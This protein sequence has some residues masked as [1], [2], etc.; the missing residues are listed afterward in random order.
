M[1]INLLTLGLAAGLLLA[2][3]SA[4]SSETD[5]RLV[6][7]P[8]EVR[9]AP[10]GFRCVA[11]L[12]LEAPGASR[13][14]IRALLDEEIALA[15]LPPIGS[16]ASESPGL[17]IRLGT[18]SGE[19]AWPP[20]PAEGGPEAY[21]LSIR[22]N[23]VVAVG[24]EVN[25]LFYA[26]QTLR[27]LIRANRNG[28][29]LPC[30]EIRDWPSLRWRAFQDDMTR[31]P[32]SR[33]DTLRFEAALGA[34]LKFNL[35]TYY[36]EYQFAFRK[37]PEIG[38][39]DGSLTP[40]D[41][42]GLVAFA[43]PF[44][45][46]VLGNQQSFG[47]FGRILKHPTYAAL[48]EN[49]DVLTPVR[50]ETYQLLDDFY[51]EVCPLV[52][53][54]WFNVCCD[55]TWGLGSGPSKDLAA[56]IGTGGVYVQHVRRVHDLLRD[57]HNKRMMMWGDIILQHPDKLGEIPKDMIM[58]TWGYDARPSFED[59]IIPFARSGFEFFVCPGVNNWSRIL[60]DFGVAVTNIQQFVR[61]GA[62][63]GA[64]GMINTDW[65]DDGEAL[66]AVKWHADAWAAECAWN[67]ST[68][69]ID[70]FNRRVGAVL[71]GEPGDRFGRAI[72]G[73]TQ[74]HRQ[75]A[76]KGLF[77]SRFW[78]D[79]FA[80]KSSPAAIRHSA[81]NLLA[82]VRTARLEI[83][84]CCA[85]AR[86]NRHILDVYRFG[87]R[88]IE[89]IGQRMLDGLAAA[90]LYRQAW[91]H[92][93]PPP[94]PPTT[95]ANPT[96][97]PGTRLNPLDAL[98][99]VESLV[100]ENRDAHAALGREFAA[101]WLEESKPYALD[102]TL[103]RYTN[104]VARYDALL[105]ALEQARATATAGHPL[106]APEKVGLDIPRPLSR[107]RL[108]QDTRPSALEADAPWLD[109]AASKRLGLTVR[110]GKIDR[111]DLPVEVEL[112]APTGLAGRPVRAFCLDPDKP[113]E[114]LAQLDA[115]PAAES[116]DRRD[117]HAGER[118]TVVLS[119]PLPRGHEAIVHVYLDAG[120]PAQ[121][122]AGAVRTQA[123]ASQ[124]QWIEN[125]RVRL[126]LG[127]EGAH[128]YRWEVK[129]AGNRDV[130]MP[131]ESGWAGFSDQ[132][133]L[134]SASHRLKCTARGPALV[135]FACT[136][137][138]GQGK[139]LRLCAGASWIEVMTQEPATL[140]W[141]FDDPRNFAADG[142]TPGT[143]L[144]SNGQSGP[145]GRE[146]DGVPA[147]VE[148]AN[149]LWG[150][151]Y[152]ADHLAL[153]MVTPG[154]RTLHHIAPGAGAGGV[155]I[156]HSP[157]AQHFV[158]FAGILNGPPA[159]AMDRLAATLDLGQPVEVCLHAPQLRP[160][161]APATSANSN[162]TRTR[163]AP[164][165]FFALCMDTHDAKHR[166]LAQQAD[167]LKELGYAGAAHLWLDGLAERLQT[168]DAAG[169][170]LYQIY[171]RVDLNPGAAAPFD[172][173]L[174]DAM[175][176]LKGRDV[177]LGLL[178]SGAKPSDETVDP[179]AL[180]L[181]GTIAD[182]CQPA[183]VR[184]A[185]YPHAGD[186]LERVEDAWRVAEKANRPDLGIMF[187]L[188]HWLRVGPERDFRSLL[189]RVRPRLFAVTL[190]GAD[191]FD[192]QPGFGRYIQPLGRGSFDMPA[193]LR[194]LRDIGYAGP[195]GLQCY[196]IEG[197][198]RDHLAESI[199]AWRNYR[200]R[201]APPD[202]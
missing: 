36:M 89:R 157:P 79:D 137:D 7:F 28:D 60:P 17:V 188:C 154:R 53:F 140:Y 76:M 69:P 110:A 25:G 33:L 200:S 80:P 189:D 57:R 202:E 24:R 67:A 95:A 63:H 184:L 94:T 107:M 146:A 47:H 177:M 13:E 43:R 113:R 142:P 109:A 30:L 20:L 118:L 87:A 196:G 186:W 22:T 97:A 124:T 45:L 132:A 40:E 180:D 31:G 51:A 55:E 192:P 50:E 14:A 41:L 112:P 164:N 70:L 77:N 62:K 185:L 12:T 2:A 23:A 160:A 102:W 93:L 127:P 44:R 152:N 144:F 179:R 54:P 9:A 145:V 161:A 183:G 84:T 134:R 197:D 98:V 32:S 61:D 123:G 64:L 5:L 178:L 42:A 181:L 162:P 16:R 170:K 82:I 27:Q 49:A 26:L 71:F 187:N 8:K 173:R 133:P 78:E 159:E 143:W 59:Q 150:I 168:L 68:T 106:P 99:K 34:Y 114:L 104:A 125:D 166:T 105:A 66:N 90:E 119:G 198:A 149:T 58:L 73:L 74:V 3:P 163:I 151:K 148:A 129:A 195:I 96:P 10:G 128:V 199:A 175:P 169:L 182:I 48:R 65:E 138:S 174:K 131:G 83:E 158:T 38:P 21:A 120:A 135:E 101:L 46:D 171:F 167:L 191:T 37:H 85:E 172:P 147:Q 19:T 156:E 100:R 117:D 1:H 139:T 115:L 52:P 136:T 103:H 91:E 201:L 111:F 86:V 126:Q 75:P 11:G 155:G 130:T 190:N 81:T 29:A 4:A 141:D 92:S 121:P 56:R 108:P 88:R 18:E 165:P 72:A 39:P 193:L 122:V 35:M 176:L 153:G 6:P 116:A 15:H 194:A